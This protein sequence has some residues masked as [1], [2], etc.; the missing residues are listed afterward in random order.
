MISGV[1]F[2]LEDGPSHAPELDDRALIQ[3]SPSEFFGRW[4]R[5]KAKGTIYLA[6]ETVLDES[7]VDQA[8]TNLRNRD[9]KLHPAFAVIGLVLAAACV[10]LSLPWWSSALVLAGVAI[11]WSMAIADQH[12]VGMAL[13]EEALIVAATES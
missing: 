13:I 12:N 8:I 9:R 3:S 4:G 2:T 10:A 6:H 11:D 5:G 1:P 7:S